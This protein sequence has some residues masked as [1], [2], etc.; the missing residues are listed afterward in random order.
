MG[1]VGPGSPAQA[2]LPAWGARAVSLTPAPDVTP[3][4]EQVVAGSRSPP[5]WKPPF[6]QTTE[7]E[8]HRQEEDSQD[9]VRVAHE[10]HATPTPLPGRP[11]WQGLRAQHEAPWQHPMRSPVAGSETLASPPLRA[12]SALR[13]IL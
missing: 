1:S 11:A 2:P 10:G 13:D 7:S 8:S 12:R 5:Q 9:T 4:Q 6:T 3:V